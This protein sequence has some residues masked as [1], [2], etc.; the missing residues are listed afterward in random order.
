MKEFKASFIPAIL[1]SLNK[2]Y[3]KEESLL[4]LSDEESDILFTRYGKEATFVVETGEING[5]RYAIV[6][7]FSFPVAFI[8]APDVLTS[9]RTSVEDWED[10]Q[11]NNKTITLY[12]EMSKYLNGPAIGWDYF[13]F[14][15]NVDCFKENSKPSL[16]EVKKDIDD[17][18]A[19]VQQKMM[20]N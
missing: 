14:E 2:R 13:V 11:F 20:S 5:F 18:I 15:D 3:L 19:A 6:S 4:S 16:E 12:E 10:I 17:A 7:C 9:T 1:E 8:S